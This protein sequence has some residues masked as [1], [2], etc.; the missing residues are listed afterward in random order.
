MNVDIRVPQLVLAGDYHD[1]DE[2]NRVVRLLNPRLG[3]AEISYIGQGQ[4][5]G[6]IY[7]DQV[8]HVSVIRQLAQQQNI[9]GDLTE[10]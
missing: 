3:V 8:P 1:F 9:H 6:V 4:Y 10:I 2:M 7:L 5:L